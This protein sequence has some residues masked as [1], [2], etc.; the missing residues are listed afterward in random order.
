M[1]QA[2]AK[3]A[4]DRCHSAGDC[5]EETYN[6]RV[7]NLS[8]GRGVFVPMPRILSARQWNRLEAGIVW[9]RLRAIMAGECKRQQRLRNHLRAGNDPLVLTVGAMKTMN[10]ASRTDDGSPATVKR[11]HHYDHVVSRRRRSGICA[12]LA[13]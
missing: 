10:T 11:A 6:I 9:S 2:R 5:A 12:V 3:T 13:D 1:A 7:I 8:L 4:G